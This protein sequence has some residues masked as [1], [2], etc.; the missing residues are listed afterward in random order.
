MRAL[1][2]SA[3][4]FRIGLSSRRAWLFILH[5]LQPGGQRRALSRDMHAIIELLG[6]IA[7]SPVPMDTTVGNYMRSHRWAEIALTL[8]SRVLVDP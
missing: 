7:I 5:R 6:H 3:V 2:I 1:P 4:W 8:P